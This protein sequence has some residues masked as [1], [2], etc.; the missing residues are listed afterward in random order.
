VL[1][2]LLATPEGFGMVMPASLAERVQQQ[3][4][5]Y[6]LRA[7]V[8]FLPAGQRWHALAV[9]S[10][11]DRALLDAR[12]L[13][14][15]PLT[16]ASKRRAGVSAVRLD[17]GHDCIEVYGDA[18]EIVSLDVN[19]KSPLSPREW[20]AARIAAGIADIDARTSGKF[21][22]HMLNLDR[23]DAVSFD[24]GCYPGQEVLARTQHIGS[25][26]RR[27]Q[28]YRSTTSAVTGTRLRH[29]GIDV[30]EIVSSSGKD[31]LAL[32]PVALHGA[33]LT[34]DGGEALPLPAGE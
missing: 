15:G 28:L 7:K 6:R 2:R 25:S 19:F 9:Q 22:P 21:T 4:Q 32:A 1:L 26:K 5:M 11:R 17:G 10:P 27:L 3:L 29:D 14:P 8:D 24:K 33:V 30:G 34:F 31:L 20:H 16:N 23:L 13:L 12:D 18:A